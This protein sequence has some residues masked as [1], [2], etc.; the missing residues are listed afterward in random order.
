[1][2][3]CIWRRL[4]LGVAG[5]ALFACGSGSYGTEVVFSSDRHGNSEIFVMNTDGS[6]IHRLTEND[7]GDIDPAWSP[8]GEEVVFSS[9]RD[10]DFEIFV[11]NTDGSGIRQLTD[12]GDIDLYTLWSPDG[13]EIAFYSIRDGNF[14][15][16]LMN[17]DGSGVTTLGQ[18][19]L[20]FDWLD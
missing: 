16:F 17:A 5:V 10:G 1:M 4:S 7:V 3:R 18:S 11:M 14:G 13:K 8:S 12:N 6:G 19:D 2:H 15:M 20:W 9:D